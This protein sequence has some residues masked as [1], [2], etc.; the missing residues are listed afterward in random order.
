V[1]LFYQKRPAQGA[2]AP[3]RCRRS[4]S[5][6]CGDRV[7]HR[8][9]ELSGGQQQRAAIARALVGKPSV[10]MAD[11]PTGNLDS[12][13]GEAILSTLDDLHDEGM[14]IIMVTHDDSVADRCQRSSACAT[15]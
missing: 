14:T 5:W 1:P 7:G 11:E 15:D 10:L 9:K 3:R 8:P 12:T 6:A 2:P 4:T 13:T